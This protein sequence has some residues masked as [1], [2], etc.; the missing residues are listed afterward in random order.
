MDKII[1]TLQ[2]PRL[3]WYQGTDFSTDVG[4]G[5][6]LRREGM[7]LIPEYQRPPVWTDEQNV[8]FLESLILGLPVGSYTLYQDNDYNFYEVMDG[9]QRWNAIFGYVDDEFEVFGFKYSQ[10]NSRSQRWFRARQFGHKML[11]GLTPEQRK[12]GYERMAYGGTPH[13]KKK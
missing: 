12:E 6:L 11:V 7:W 13:E 8:K 10:L 3:S 9:Q 1:E 2:F 5:L 4:H